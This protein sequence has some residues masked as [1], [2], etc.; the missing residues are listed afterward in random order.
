MNL[1]HL[2]TLLIASLLAGACA[3]EPAPA[4]GANDQH[5]DERLISAALDTVISFNKAEV[6]GE[7]LSDEIPEAFWAAEIEALNPLAVYWH[8]NNLAVV[9][10]S[11]GAETDGAYIYLPISSYWPP[12]D[13]MQLT[14]GQE[15]YLFAVKK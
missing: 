14:F 9:L 10:N 6:R 8:N 11:A 7:T 3:G 4:E 15:T 5:L 1:K 2:I 13:T 12:N